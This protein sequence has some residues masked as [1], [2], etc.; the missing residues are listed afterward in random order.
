[1]KKV[2]KYILYHHERWDGKGYPLHLK[3]EEIPYKVRVL[4]LLDYYD[5]ITHDRPYRPAVEREVALKRI[6]QNSG[7]RFDPNLTKAF[8]DFMQKQ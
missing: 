2:S 1:M 4:S 7:R 8:I 5:S 6:R 3:G